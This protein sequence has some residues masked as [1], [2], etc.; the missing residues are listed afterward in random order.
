[1]SSDDTV[2]AVRDLGKRY[3]IYDAPRDRLKQMILPR[4][5]RIAGRAAR[6]MHLPLDVV[7]RDYFR[8]FWAL[9]GVSFDVRR[10]ESLGILGRNGAGKSTLLQI[11]CGTLAPTLGEVNVSGRISALLELGSG[12][13]PDYTGRENIFLNAVLLGLS[14]ADTASR[15]EDIATFADIG[16][17]IEQPVKTYSSGMVLRL[18]FA[19]A[20]HVSP[21][22][23]VVDEALA[24]GDVGFQARCFARIA[25]LRKNGLT[26]L[27]VSH[28]PSAVAQVCDRAIFLDRGELVLQG[29][30]YQAIR[31]YNHIANAG[32]KSLLEVRKDVIELTA[33]EDAH[34]KE[35][36]IGAFTTAAA[37]RSPHP[38]ELPAHFDSSLLDEAKPIAVT[39]RG[40]TI[41]EYCVLDESDDVVNVLPVHRTFTLR[42]AVSLRAQFDGVRV[43]WVLK[44]PHGM[45]L[46]GGA[47][48]HPGG[49][50]S[51]GP[52]RLE[53]RSKFI[54]VFAAGLYLIDI[55][56]RGRLENDDEI[57]HAVANAICIRSV[58]YRGEFRNGIVDCLIPGSFDMFDASGVNL[59]RE[60][61]R[62]VDVKHVT[63]A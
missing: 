35:S 42:V 26:L 46:G 20:V 31:A 61:L 1:M 11:V 34:E 16:D 60:D 55:N 21:E 37:G 50:V 2:I 36:P 40:G 7:Q 6:G 18:A 58:S 5:R 57:I 8:E 24:V 30:T 13:H 51:V 62:A 38:A 45:I 47:S 44:S 39:E 53:I 15:F 17:F 4:L 28:S 54:N 29:S 3:E 59:V 63:N 19:V 48:H 49:G 43:G 41:L 23:L 32:A 33:A 10:G 14:E 25:E 56:L 12:F 9:R 22:V 27:F 52:Q